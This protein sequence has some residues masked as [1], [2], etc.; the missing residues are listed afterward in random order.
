MAGFVV[1][2]NGF[3]S[4]SACMADV[5]ETMIANGFTQIYPVTAFEA[6]NVVGD[7]FKVTLEASSSVDPLQAT[8]PWRIHIEAVSKDL[9][10]VVVATPTQLLV[11]GTYAY[12]TNISG[13]NIDVLGSVGGQVTTGEYLPTNLNCGFINRTT[14]VGD[15]GTSY[16]LSYSLS[17]S[18]RGLFIG[19]W[20]EAVTTEQ[21]SFFNWLMV[22]RPVDRDTGSVITTGKSPVW[23]VNSTNN[24]F[25][26]FIVRESDILRPGK[27]RS[28]S[29]NTEDS[30]AILNVETQ[31][32]LTEDGKY[33]V[34]FPSRLNTSRY[35]YSYELDMVGITS[36]DVVS[37][38]SDVELTVY[39]ELT[40]RVY[41][42]L[43]SNKSNNTGMRLL[44]LQS[45]G[46]I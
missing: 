17:I 12:E 1:E 32:R 33:V 7:V 46:G 23:C 14:R 10:S 26:Q 11:D 24:L 27:R 42:A 13:G 22:Q 31:V 21:S 6:A 37:Q 3:I 34:N 4:A 8:Q 36:A 43:Q 16:P 45:G 9:V 41:H 35:R 2:K 30:E 38:Y 19:T 18:P 29:A 15:N 20:E 5:A 40:P 25:Y 44:V 28:A 39:G